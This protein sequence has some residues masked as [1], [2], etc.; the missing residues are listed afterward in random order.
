MR[1]TFTAAQYALKSNPTLNT[2]QSLSKIKPCLQE[3]SVAC[4]ARPSRE[5]EDH[6]NGLALNF[7][8]PWTALR[9]NFAWFFY[10][11]R[12]PRTETLSFS[13]ISV[14]FP[15]FLCRPLKA[16]V[17]YRRSR[18]YHSFP[19]V[20]EGPRDRVHI[21]TGMQPERIRVSH[22]TPQIPGTIVIR[23]HVAWLFN[24]SRIRRWFRQNTRAAE[25]ASQ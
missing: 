11:L 9:L 15:H 20:D 1:Y 13:S 8:G 10:F 7:H 16:T 12:F 5:L 19:V 25:I 4:D 14:N 17:P 6:C 2:V 24:S 21:W 18:I 23:S 22:V 3:R